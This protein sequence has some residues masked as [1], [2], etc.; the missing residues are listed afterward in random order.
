MGL[1]KILKLLTKSPRVNGWIAALATSPY[2]AYK[3]HQYSADGKDHTFLDF[4]KTG[5]PSVTAFILAYLGTAV[6]HVYTKETDTGQRTRPGD[7][8]IMKNLEAR[9]A[10]QTPPSVFFAGEKDIPYGVLNLWRFTHLNGKTLEQIARNE[11][12]PAIAIDAMLLYCGSEHKM[13]DGLL[14]LTD[15]YEWLNNR[16]PKFSRSGK[17]ACAYRDFVFSIARW[18]EPRNVSEYILAATHDSILRPDH[19]WYWSAL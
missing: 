9:L 18:L 19:A 17:I 6:L 13:D 5:I 2:M 15:A 7:R 11:Q 1:G 12:N 10:E 14:L 3:F 8:K 4:A 16:K